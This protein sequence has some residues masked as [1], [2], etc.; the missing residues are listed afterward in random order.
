VDSLTFS[1]L[2]DRPSCN[3]QH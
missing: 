2:A 3:V 1:P